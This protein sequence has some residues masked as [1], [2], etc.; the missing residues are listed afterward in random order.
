MAAN[1]WWQYRI[2]SGATL[3]FAAVSGQK[4]KS[5]AELRHDSARRGC[6]L[7][8]EEIGKR[9]FVSPLTVKKNMTGIHRKSGISNR[10]ELLMCM[11][12]RAS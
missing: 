5:A 8:N 2:P 11:T 10:F 1:Q 3:S 9:L 12:A 6:L 7:S 4:Y